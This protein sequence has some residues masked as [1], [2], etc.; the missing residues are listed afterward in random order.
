MIAFRNIRA[1]TILGYIG[2][3]MKQRIDYLVPENIVFGEKVECP[4]EYS[5]INVS[6]KKIF[7][8]LK[9][10]SSKFRQLENDFYDINRRGEESVDRI[11][12]IA[13]EI[14]TYKKTYAPILYFVHGKLE[15]ADGRHR[16]LLIKEWLDLNKPYITEEIIV[17]VPT[18]QLSLFRSNE[19]MLY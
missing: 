16:I 4:Q 17:V 3:F 9:K 10:G 2:K 7:E 8:A 19:L 11:G 15:I 6:T 18:S 12:R 13:E 5:V 14:W 1:F